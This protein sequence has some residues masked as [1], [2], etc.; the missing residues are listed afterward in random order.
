M[1]RTTLTFDCPEFYDLYMTCHMHGW[2]NLAPFSWDEDNQALRLALGV[3]GASMDIEVKQSGAVLHARV[4]S[5]V[6]M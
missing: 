5:G 4:I 3:D 2:K 6:K 1:R